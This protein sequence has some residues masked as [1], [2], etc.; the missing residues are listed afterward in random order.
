MVPEAPVDDEDH[1]L[2][3]LIARVVV[4]AKAY[5]GAEIALYREQATI[6]L[7]GVRGAA[8]MIGIALVL[9]IGASMLLLVALMLALAPLIGVAWSALL[10]ALLSAAVAGVLGWLAAR[11]VSAALSQLGK[12][13]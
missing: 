7:G 4:D 3:A 2:G 5:I 10:V 12:G 6:V 11:R 9:A 13:R 8:V 1:T